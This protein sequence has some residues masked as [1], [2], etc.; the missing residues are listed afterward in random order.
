MT[1]L[2]DLK[3]RPI[4]ELSGDDPMMGWMGCWRMDR[5]RNVLVSDMDGCGYELDLDPIDDKN[6][7][8]AMKAMIDSILHVGGKSWASAEMLAEMSLFLAMRIKVRASA[9]T[10]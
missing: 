6:L 9:V 5:D 1:N 3:P 4:R 8:R 10:T 7:S 2:D